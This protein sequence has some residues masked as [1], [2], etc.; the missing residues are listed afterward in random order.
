MPEYERRNCI[1]VGGRIDFEV[2]LWLASNLIG[3][4]GPSEQ[5]GTD[6]PPDWLQVQLAEQP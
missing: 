6:R 3:G 5:T 2:M 1:S 4:I